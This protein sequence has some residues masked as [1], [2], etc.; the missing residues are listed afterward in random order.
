MITNRRERD[1]ISVS[2]TRSSDVGAMKKRMKDALSV[3]VK[4]PSGLLFSGGSIMAKE[5]PMA[6][7][8]KFGTFGGTSDNSQDALGDDNAESQDD[9]ALIKDI[10]AS[11]VPPSAPQDIIEPPDSE[12]DKMTES[13]RQH[14]Q[15]GRAMASSIRS[16]VKDEVDTTLDE[17]TRQAVRTALRDE[18]H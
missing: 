14:W 11:E 15:I 8:I 1:A 10:L 17:M 12:S 5:L 16:I 4:P 6:T 13:E 2:H 9:D 18:G 7:T 3:D